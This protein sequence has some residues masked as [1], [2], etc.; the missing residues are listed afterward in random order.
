[1]K[2][3]KLIWTPVWGDE[4]SFCALTPIAGIGSNL[5]YIHFEQGKYWANWDLTITGT[6][7][8]QSLKDDAQKKHDAWFDQWIEDHA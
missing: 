1:M 7:D 8:L 4:Q 3:K 5:I 6:T 2:I